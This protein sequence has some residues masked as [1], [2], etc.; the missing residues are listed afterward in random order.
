MASQTLGVI[1]SEGAGIYAMFI[2]SSFFHIHTIGP[3]PFADYPSIKTPRSINKFD[4]T[5]SMVK[6]PHILRA[7][8]PRGEEE[9]LSN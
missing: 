2:F 4:H 6:R 1:P 7:S 5:D 3:I 9:F 8:Y